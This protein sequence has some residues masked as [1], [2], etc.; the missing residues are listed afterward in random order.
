MAEK[1]TR[2]L[3][4]PEEQEE[5][6][7]WRMPDVSH[8]IARPDK[9]LFGHVPGELVLPL[10]NDLTM[11]PPT[12]AEL[13]QIRLEAE[14]E[15]FAEGRAQGLEQGLEAGRLEGLMQGHQQ[16]FSQGEQQGYE[17]GMAK[18]TDMMARFDGLIS[19]FMAPLSLLDDEIEYQLLQLTQALSQAVIGHELSIKPEHILHTLKQGIAALPLASKT[20]AIHL[21][22][23]DIQLVTTLYG[24]EHMEHNGW[25]LQADPCLGRGDCQIA[26][27]RSLVD[28]SLQPR[29][30]AVLAQ[31]SAQMQQLSNQINDKQAT[32]AARS[33]SADTACDHSDGTDTS[34]NELASDSEPNSVVTE[35]SAIELDNLDASTQVMR[36]E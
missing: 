6:D 11:M 1:I 35:A 4:R 30:Q 10:D 22:P 9:D 14:Q 20:I 17:Q 2:Y 8:D 18:A 5:F 15:G 19:Q 16:G 33:T 25:Q 36:E 29:L 31:T 3:V 13:E 32:L 24:A 12:M 21:H 23:D 26:S 7:A 34:D 28:L 27:G